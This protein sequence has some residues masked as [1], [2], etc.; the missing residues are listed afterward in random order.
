MKELETMSSHAVFICISWYSKICWFPLKKCWC[1]QNSRGVSLDLYIFWIF[2]MWGIP[3]P[4]FIIVEYAWQVLGWRS[5]FATPS[6]SNHKKAHPGS[7]K[8]SYYPSYIT[9]GWNLLLLLLKYLWFQLSVS[10]ICSEK[11]ENKKKKVQNLF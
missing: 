4:S 8:L 2:F 9:Q 5:L 1:Q 11:T 6:M 3:V 10:V 7:Q